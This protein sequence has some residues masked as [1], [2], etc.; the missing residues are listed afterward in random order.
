MTEP[1]DSRT[2]QTQ[3]PGSLRPL[4]GVVGR[5]LAITRFFAAL[6]DGAVYGLLIVLGLVV[7]AK[8]TPAIAPN[9]TVVLAVLGVLVL[10][11]AFAIAWFT[12]PSQFSIAALLDERLGVKD[13]FTT[14]I[15]CAHRDD[16]FAQAA[17]QDALECAGSS[18]MK[19]RIAAAFAPQAP[20]GVWIA[21][22][23]G[24]LAFMLWMTVPAGDLFAAGDP[25]AIAQAEDE[26]QDAEDT[27]RAVLEQ[28]EE[29]PSLSE[30]LGEIGDAFALDESRPDATAE[31]GRRE[32][33]RRVSDLDRRL[34]DL[35]SGEKSMEL[36]AMQRALA[37]MESL[38][39]GE[40]RE[41]SEALRNGDFSKAAEA[42]KALQ[43]K[44]EQQELS[45]EE[46]Q[47]LAAQLE[48]LAEQ[49]AE[50]AKNTESLE[51]A[52]QRAGLDSSLAKNPEALQQA[53]QQATGLNEQQL[54]ELQQMMNAQKSSSQNCKNMSGAMNKM[55]QQCQQGQPGESGSKM[56]QCLSQQEQ[57]QQM[58]MAAQDCQSQCQ[59]GGGKPGG[60]SV[61]PTT[62]QSGASQGNQPGKGFG[63][64][65][66]SGGLGDVAI[67]S[68]R[69]STRLQKEQV[70]LQEGGDII[71]RQ[72]VQSDA[73]LVGTSTLKLQSTADRIMLG[74]E[75]GV[76]D[77]PIPN[78]L[79]D[80][81]MHYFG[82]MKERIRSRVRNTPKT[83]TA[84]SDDATTPLEPTETEKPE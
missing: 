20:G 63:A 24:L 80:A 1:Q 70:A 5:R 21:P 47:E 40:A 61:L 31:D 26:R 84:P 81:Q 29:N 23:M 68:T 4:I 33:L 66:G 36:S 2:E 43:E 12:R 62:L 30:E 50:A 58:M 49:L 46:K 59:G 55:A 52:L 17:L 11:L 60:A 78:A 74:W 41:M 35:L 69:F 25:D 53:L 3:V 7:A 76:E 15:H 82:V 67:E 39:Q 44:L 77:Q 8:M 73:P 27:M 79:R 34:E 83:D 71:S 54:Q 56:G 75:E 13:R 32:A 14:A 64:K 9:W 45:E 19:P 42:L 16:P 38:E 22:V 28:I 18:E 72:L 51:E 57:L 65:P 10:L 48:K 37:Q 6:H